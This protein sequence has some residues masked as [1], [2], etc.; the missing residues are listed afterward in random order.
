MTD[1]ETY[2]ICEEDADVIENQEIIPEPTFEVNDR[3]RQPVETTGQEAL[4]AAASQIHM[5]KMSKKGT[6]TGK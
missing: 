2:G 3:K 5:Q 1:S 6:T 4:L